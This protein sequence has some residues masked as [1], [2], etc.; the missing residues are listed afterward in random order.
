MANSYH[1]GQVVRLTATFTDTGGNFADPT[2]VTFT[3]EDPSGNNST[4]WSTST[5]LVAHPST[6]VYTLDVPVDEAGTW[7][8][9]VN[10]TGGVTTAS[11]TYFRVQ[12]TKVSS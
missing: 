12:H 11:E 2:R 5:G 10:S 7:P 9:K 3:V 6:G 1:I 8:Y 4:E